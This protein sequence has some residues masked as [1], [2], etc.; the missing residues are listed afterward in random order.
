MNAAQ[1]S[2][3]K[4]KVAE[5]LKRAQER[6]M[7]NTT[8]WVDEQYSHRLAGQ[9]REDIHKSATE[10]P[11]RIKHINQAR[12]M[13]GYICEEP[14]RGGTELYYLDNSVHTSDFCLLVDRYDETGRWLGPSK[15]QTD[16]YVSYHAILRLFQRLRSNSRGDLLKAVKS[17]FTLPNTNQVGVETKLQT[18]F[19]S[20]F[21]TTFDIALQQPRWVVKT[22]IA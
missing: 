15:S 11:N 12:K 4:R 2:L 13:P 17:L 18:D 22:F 16:I 19:G 6:H 7:P 8:T 10:N 9:L 3:A 1:R 5:L 14:I 21:L 20:F